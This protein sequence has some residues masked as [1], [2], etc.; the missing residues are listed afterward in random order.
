MRP[1]FPSKPPA[2]RVRQ[3]LSPGVERSRN[4]ARRLKSDEAPATRQELV[5][6]IAR[7]LQL[8]PALLDVMRQGAEE[9]HD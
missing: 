2:P 4:F 3:H 5:E 1:T 8:P 7:N 6:D 9:D